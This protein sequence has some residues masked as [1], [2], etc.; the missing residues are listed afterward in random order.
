M[1]LVVWVSQLAAL[2]YRSPGDKCLAEPGPQ[3]QGH[4]I[5]R[6]SGEEPTIDARIGKMRGPNVAQR[7][8]VCGKAPREAV[9][10]DVRVNLSLGWML[11][12]DGGRDRLDMAA[13]HGF[14]AHLDAVAFENGPRPGRQIGAAECGREPRK[15]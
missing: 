7:S 13:P 9:D 11:L 4:R 3:G 12:R 6:Q 1:H 15:R 10:A 2:S 5:H 14:R 8:V